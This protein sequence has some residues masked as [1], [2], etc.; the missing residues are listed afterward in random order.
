MT[1]T[2]ELESLENL[3]KTLEGERHR[4]VQRLL[5]NP[6]AKP[7]MKHN[8]GQLA[9]IHSAYLAVLAEIDL[10]TPKVGHGGET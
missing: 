10:H 4:L 6:G 3:M 8:I 7:E 9:A 1:S 5:A 2:S